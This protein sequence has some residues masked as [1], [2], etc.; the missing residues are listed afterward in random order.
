M[1]RRNLHRRPLVIAFV[2]LILLLQ[3]L[4]VAGQLP[5]T[6]WVTSWGQSMTSHAQQIMGDQDHLQHDAAGHPV[7]R[8]PSVDHLTVRQLVTA[9]V[10]GKQARVALSNTFG[11][12]PL[13]ITAARIALATGNG[14][15]ID[16]ATDRPLTFNGGHSIVTIAP[17]RTVRSDPVVMAVPALTRLAISLY[18]DSPARLADVHVMESERTTFFARGDAT[19]ATQLQPMAEFGA[20][21]KNANSRIFV[22]AGVDV[23][24]PSSVR[25]IVAMGDSI[26][27]GAYASSNTAPWPAALAALANGPGGTPAAVSNAGISG[28]E[29]TTDQIGNPGAGASGLKRYLRDVID[30]PGVT[31]VVV[32]FGANDL[33][34]GIDAAGYPHGA[35]AGD[36]IAGLAML[37]DVAHQ[38]HLRVYAGTITPIAGF[39]APGWY[40]PE[41]ESIRQR[42]NRWIVDSKRFDGVIDFAAA[43]RGPYK[44]ASLATTQ[45]PL[46]PGMANA[47]AGDAGLHPNDRGYAAMAVAAYNVL[48]NAHRTAAQPCD[49]LLVAH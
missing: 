22:L 45:H 31:D 9:S 49:L 1:G 37:A 18:F 41:K 28:N 24:A 19:R 39:P 13:T 4:A 46:P 5:A 17:G 20:L 3:T 2:L 42:V 27:D 29:L 44:P 12:Q 32:L 38:H 15:A 36:I 6:R 7:E 21:G 34:R 14:S 11:Q 25:G 35:S 8:A 40:S 10:G 33:N 16:T 23:Q 43:V 48:F 26:T 30:Q 47:C